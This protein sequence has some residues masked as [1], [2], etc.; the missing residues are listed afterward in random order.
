MQLFYLFVFGYESATA[1]SLAYKM[2]VLCRTAVFLIFGAMATQ[3]SCYATLRR[4]K[5]ICPRICEIG[6]S[7]ARSS[8][9]NCDVAMIIC[10]MRTV[11]SRRTNWSAGGKLDLDGRHCYDYDC[12]VKKLDN[13]ELRDQKRRKKSD[14]V[15]FYPWYCD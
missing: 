15:F 10:A 4:A 1:I 5:A 11:L 3:R 7:V 9:R 12:T 8:G 2:D 14:F 6:A 13:S